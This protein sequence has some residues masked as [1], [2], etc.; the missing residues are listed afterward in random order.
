MTSSRKFLQQVEKGTN[1]LQKLFAHSCLTN[2]RS[3]ARGGQFC[4][5]LYDYSLSTHSK[6]RDMYQAQVGSEF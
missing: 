6:V 1:T 4:H 3:S 2:Y 5:K